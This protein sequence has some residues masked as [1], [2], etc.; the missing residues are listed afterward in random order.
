MCVCECECVCVS[1]NVCVCECE[2]VCVVLSIKEG[3]Q[4]KYFL[5]MYV[6][7][8]FRM[9]IMCLNL[10]YNKSTFNVYFNLLKT[11]RNPLYIRNQSV[12]R[13]KHFPPRL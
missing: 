5:Q 2:C 4:L 7:I 11:K 12:P 9:K 10:P 3:E 6:F 8:K 13:C 1:V